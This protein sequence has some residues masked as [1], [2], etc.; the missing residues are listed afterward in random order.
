MSAGGE[1]CEDLR[2]HAEEDFPQGQLSLPSEPS[3]YAGPPPTN[4][5][6]FPDQSED[7]NPWP[8]EVEWSIDITPLAEDDRPCWG[9]GSGDD[10]E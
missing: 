7:E 8:L 2:P 9:D 6:W 5:P 10:G 1:L 4:Q 3:A